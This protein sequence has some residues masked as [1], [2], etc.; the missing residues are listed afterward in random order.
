MPE[1]NFEAVFEDTIGHSTPEL[2]LGK[3]RGRS[4]QEL[5]F[6]PKM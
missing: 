3:I 2:D 5:R 1:L 4:S 6:E